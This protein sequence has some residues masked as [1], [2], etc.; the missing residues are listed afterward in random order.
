MS[1]YLAAYDI[2]DSKRRQSVARLLLGHGNRL[3]RSVFEV[4][5]EPGEVRQ[6]C[7][8]VG[9]HLS[10][11]DVFQLFPLDERGT[12]GRISWREPDNGFDPV[13]II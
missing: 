6:L 11:T 9:P 10:A 3:Q 5:L 2:T 12:R 13:M 8:E 7:R 1:L 4:W